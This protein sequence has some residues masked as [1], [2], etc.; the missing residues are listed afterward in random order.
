MISSNLLLPT[1]S[2]LL[3][4]FRRGRGHYRYRTPSNPALQNLCPTSK[5]PMHFS[6]G[7]RSRARCDAR[8]FQYYIFA[9]QW[10][11]T[12]C[13]MLG[14]NCKQVPSSVPR[15]RWTIHGLWPTK[16]AVS[17]E[18][19]KCEK[20]P[21]PFHQ[22]WAALPKR[23]KDSLRVKWPDLKNGGLPFQRYQWTKHGSCA[24]MPF[25]KY[26]HDALRLS[27]TFNVYNYL[28]KFNIVPSKTP[29]SGYFLEK[30]R[31]AIME[32]VGSQ[33][34]VIIRCWKGELAEIRICLDRQFRP[35]GCPKKRCLAQSS[36]KRRGLLFQGRSGAVQ[37]PNGLAPCDRKKK[38]LYP[39]YWSRLWSSVLRSGVLSISFYHAKIIT[40]LRADFF[41][42]NAFLIVGLFINVIWKDPVFDG[43][44]WVGSPWRHTETSPH[45]TLV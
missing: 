43:L 5:R 31:N 24:G 2:R 33:G 14:G 15:N 29:G 38:I 26:F 34:R 7:L 4:L 6:S 40:Q 21:Q 30:I 3:Q 16:D 42:S 13:K 17:L 22:R 1:G 39:G 25:A 44:C 10:P 8:A 37:S 18:N 11:V 35:C 32:G 9:Q 27:D 12:A 41:A 28:Q 23:D 20:K 36:A 19:C 45:A